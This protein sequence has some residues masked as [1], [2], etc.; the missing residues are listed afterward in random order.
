MVSSGNDLCTSGDVDLDSSWKKYIV[1][2]DDRCI[3]L[4][5]IF[6][7]CMDQAG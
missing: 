3:L 6:G 1:S 5:H 2:F 4:S 7:V